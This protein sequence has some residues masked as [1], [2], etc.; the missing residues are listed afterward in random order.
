MLSMSSINNNNNNGYCYN[1][2]EKSPLSIKDSAIHFD[3]T[4]SQIH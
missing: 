2:G 1:I 3:E 4:L